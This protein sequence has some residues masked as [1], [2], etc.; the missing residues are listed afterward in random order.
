MYYK[1]SLNQFAIKQANT[2]FETISIS[3]KGF[4]D[5]Y[6]FPYP[7]NKAD[8]IFCQGF[9]FNAME[10][11]GA[12]TYNENLLYRHEPSLFEET[13]RSYIINHEYAHMWFGNTITMKWWDDM[14]LNESFADFAAALNLSDCQEKKLFSYKMSNIWLLVNDVKNM[15]Y[16]D[17]H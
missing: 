11:A 9:F 6:G 7:F 13:R 3:I 1:Q 5:L 17:D 16:N 12:V 4:E 14:W 2:I 8:T 15:A 10:N